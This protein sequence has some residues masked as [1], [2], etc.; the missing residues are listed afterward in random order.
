MPDSK[1]QKISVIQDC[2]TAAKAGIKEPF[3]KPQRFKE[4]VQVLVGGVII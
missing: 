2:E 3:S 4:R 1:G